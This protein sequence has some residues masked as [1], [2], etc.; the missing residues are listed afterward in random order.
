MR[1]ASANELRELF[2][3]C[4]LFKHGLCVVEI[5]HSWLVTAVV[6]AVRVGLENQ[7]AREAAMQLGLDDA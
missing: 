5:G 2:G 1:C 6:E 4:N 7:R 3:L